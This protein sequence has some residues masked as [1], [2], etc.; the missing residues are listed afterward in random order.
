MSDPSLPP[1]APVPR[2][3]IPITPEPASASFYEAQ[4]KIQ[5]RSI[6]GVLARW[7]WI[8]VWLT[9]L[10]FYIVPWLQWNGRQMLLFD[11][12]Q[13]RFYLFGLLLYPQDFIY[14]TALLNP[15]VLLH[16]VAWNVY[17][18]AFGAVIVLVIATVLGSPPTG[19]WGLLPRKDLRQ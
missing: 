8:M 12:E 4:V 6:K 10:F 1:R 2:K 14:L 17:W 5:P 9:Q 18:V 15:L 7:R 19:G 11:L 3:V 13:R 16:G